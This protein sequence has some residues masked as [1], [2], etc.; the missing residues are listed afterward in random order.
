MPVVHRRRASVV[1]EPRDRHVPLVDPNDPLHDTYID[2]LLLQRST[3]LD[4][5]LEVRHYAPLGASRAIEVIGIATYESNALANRL[6][7]VAHRRQLRRCQHGG[8]GVRSP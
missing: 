8:G 2:F 3:L 4:M 1:L 5:Q 7:A 6:A